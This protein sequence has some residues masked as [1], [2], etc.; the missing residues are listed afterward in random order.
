MGY[1]RE[2]WQV[3][4]T[5]DD[6]DAVRQLYPSA[7]ARGGALEVS[8]VLRGVPAGQV[9]I[10]LVD[11]VTGIG[12]FQVTSA[13]GRAR[14]AFV[15][16]GRYLVAGREV[17]P[18]GPCDFND[19]PKHFLTS[20]YAGAQSSNDPAKATPVEITEQK[21]A[22]QLPLIEGMKRFDCYYGY[23]G[24][25]H[26]L[27][28][29]GG[30][31]TIQLVKDQWEKTHRSETSGGVPSGTRVVPAGSAPGYTIAST[32]PEDPETLSF[33][34]SVAPGAAPGPRVVYAENQGEYALAAV[35]FYIVERLAPESNGH[36]RDPL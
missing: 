2:E 14:F 9:E 30:E 5:L 31:A 34:V 32:G 23:S 15:P 7:Q 13:Q 12:R 20:F 6:E 29:A 36:L 26:Y 27:V 16:L 4:S 19:R 10:A 8:A 18:T 28:A 3:F 1:R 35:G 24:A 17:I 22:I 33:K 11:A 25:S 21:T